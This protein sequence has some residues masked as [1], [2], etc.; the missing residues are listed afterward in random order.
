MNAPPRPRVRAPDH[1]VELHGDLGRRLGACDTA[2]DKNRQ[3]NRNSR[4]EGG[5]TQQSNQHAPALTN[6]TV[7]VTECDTPPAVTVSLT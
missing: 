6:V 4:K 3:S 2:P 5:S 7:F 1:E